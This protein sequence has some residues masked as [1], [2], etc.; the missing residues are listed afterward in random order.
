MR[1]VDTNVLVRLITRDDAR[2]V[3]AAD[4]FVEKGAWVPTLALT[5]ATWVLGAVYDR[6][7]G[8]IATAVEM[9]L[10]HGELTVQ[11]PDA[12]AAALAAF[13][14][15]PSLGFSDCLLLEMARSA[16]HLPLG[17][18]DRALSKLDGAAKL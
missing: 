11:N 3:T 17:T 18:F 5:E 2:Q 9:L 16:G 4:R 10:D 7:P 15:R 12:V 1:A 13:R 8:Q 14:R 6:S